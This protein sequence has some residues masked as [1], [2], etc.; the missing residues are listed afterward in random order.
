M[1]IVMFLKSIKLVKLP[2]IHYIIFGIEVC[3]L[4]KTAGQ[5]HTLLKLFFPERNIGF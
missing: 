4:S 1:L 2:I 3:R 5:T